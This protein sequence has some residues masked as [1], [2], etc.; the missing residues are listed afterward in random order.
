MTDDDHMLQLGHLDMN[1]VWP[2]G[3]WPNVK[4]HQI[5]RVLLRSSPEIENETIGQSSQFLGLSVL[6]QINSL[7]D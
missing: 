4:S 3:A 6:H 5:L 7:D 2:T 1:D